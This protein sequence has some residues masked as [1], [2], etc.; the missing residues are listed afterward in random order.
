MRSVFI[1]HGTLGP[2]LVGKGTEKPGLLFLCWHRLMS[3]ERPWC[4]AEIEILIHLHLKNEWGKDGLGKRGVW[5]QK[6]QQP[7]AFSWEGSS[8]WEDEERKLSKAPVGHLPEERRL[9][10]SVHCYSA[11]HCDLKCDYFCHPDLLIFT[12]SVHS[13]S[14]SLGWM[15]N[16]LPPPPQVQS[17]NWGF[18]L[19]CKFL[20]TWEMLGLRNW[21]L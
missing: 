19:L 5:G 2:V 18:I 12:F 17:Y 7:M 15:R 14:D 4:S 21:H 3:V 16:I 8:I 20:S 6:C 10:A 11:S 9:M 13:G 1:H